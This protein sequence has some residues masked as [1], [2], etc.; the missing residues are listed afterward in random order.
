MIKNVECMVVNWKTNNF[1]SKHNENC[2]YN[3][4]DDFNN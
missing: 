3:N 4:L 2:S 1:I